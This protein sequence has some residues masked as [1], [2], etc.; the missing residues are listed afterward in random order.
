M[1]IETKPQG[2]KVQRDQKTFT[3]KEVFIKKGT[4]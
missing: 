3:K 2:Q 4:V 1:I